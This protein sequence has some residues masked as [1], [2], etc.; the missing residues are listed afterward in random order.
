VETDAEN[1]DRAPRFAGKIPPTAGTS[2]AAT[3]RAS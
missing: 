3:W 2:S 1:P